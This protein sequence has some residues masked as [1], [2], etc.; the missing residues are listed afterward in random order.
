MAVR[1]APDVTI[2][3]GG[4][5]GCALAYYL[6]RDGV[7]VTLLERGRIGGVPS[8]SGASAAMVDFS[9]GDSDQGRQAVLTHELLPELAADVRERSGI[10]VQLTQPGLVRLAFDEDGLTALR[11]V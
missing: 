4:V 2:I 10:D 11:Q 9:V 6:A 8:A 1:R 5:M 3:G 7:Q